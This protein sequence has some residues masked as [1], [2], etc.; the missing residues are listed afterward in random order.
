M[1]ER[2]SHAVNHA[3]RGVASYVAHRGLEQCLDKSSVGP[4]IKSSC[5]YTE[6]RPKTIDYRN[7]CS[8]SKQLGYAKG[9][10]RGGG[11]A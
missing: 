4:G 1:G 8:A 6:L 7:R 2:H 11:E 5:R 9:M 10:A 3:A